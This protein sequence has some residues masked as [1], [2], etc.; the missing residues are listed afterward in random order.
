[1]ICLFAVRCENSDMN[2]SPTFNS[3]SP[4]EIVD[5]HLMERLHG[6]DHAAA[7]QIYVRYADKLLG[8]ARRHTPTDLR[9]RFDP[10]DVVQSV[11][12]TF[13]RRAAKGAYSVP[14][15]DDLWKLFL[16]IALNKIRR[17]GEFHR[18]GKRS[19]SRTSTLS[20]P[21][22]EVAET[23]ANDSIHI[24]ELTIDEILSDSPAHVRQMVKLRIEGCEV[25][26]IATRTGRSKR[27]VERVLQN[28]R[29]SLAEQLGQSGV[30]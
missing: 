27:S 14:A 2:D 19:V 28:F 30:E 24:L 22:R 17:L 11:F 7:T 21:G 18:S 3:D 13:F 8:V 6:G 25:A 15:G 1:M 29:K 4:P 10:E 9:T 12:R 26:E 20:E 16:V 5:E 23:L